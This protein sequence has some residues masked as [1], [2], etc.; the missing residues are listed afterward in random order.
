MD[1]DRFTR[2]DRLIA[3][4]IPAM[5]EPAIWFG[6]FAPQC[7]WLKGIKGAPNNAVVVLK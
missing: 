4:V 7:S 5:P 1:N 3:A 6:G 2:L